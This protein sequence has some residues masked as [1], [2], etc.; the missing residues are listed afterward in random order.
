MSLKTGAVFGN[1]PNKELPPEIEKQFLKNI[2]RFEDAW[3]NAKNITIHE[4]IGKPQ[5]KRPESLTERELSEELKIITEILLQNSITLDTIC[6]VDD[7]T[8]YTF[9]VDEF[10]KVEVQDMQIPGFMQ[11]YIYEEYHPNH[12]YDIKKLV[13]EVIKYILNKKENEFENYDVKYIKNYPELQLF[14]KAFE[15]FTLHHL[16]ISNINVE[17]EKATVTFETKFTGHMDVSSG[18]VVFQGTGTAM[19]IQNQSYWWITQLDLPS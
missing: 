3:Q 9:I 8:L 12:E 13:G 7:N 10:M 19:L 1:I 11:C 14:T 16:N 4:K 18:K 15:K 5:L 2:E 6:P 17:H